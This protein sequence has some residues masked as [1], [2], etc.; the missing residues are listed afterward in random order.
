MLRPGLIRE[1]RGGLIRVFV[2]ESVDSCQAKRAALF[3]EKLAGRDP[4][5]G[6]LPPLD[7]HYPQ[8]HRRPVRARAA[9][10]ASF[11]TGQTEALRVAA[12][13]LELLLGEQPAGE[14]LK[15]IGRS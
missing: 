7:L 3:A 2:F 15:F 11:P 4:P 10:W 6:L 14:V 5:S 12:R 1:P 13:L 8:S 9:P